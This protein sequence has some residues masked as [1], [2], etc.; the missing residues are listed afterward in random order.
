MT[1]TNQ[2]VRA[3]LKGPNHINANAYDAE[4]SVAMADLDAEY[5]AL[6]AESALLSA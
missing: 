6:V 1:R 2:P 4:V 5:E 3:K